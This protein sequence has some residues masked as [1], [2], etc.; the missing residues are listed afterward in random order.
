VKN[1]NSKANY[2]PNQT[3]IRKKKNR[4]PKRTQPGSETTPN[5][6]QTKKRDTNPEVKGILQ[7]REMQDKTRQ[8]KIRRQGY[9]GVKVTLYLPPTKT[10]S[11]S[12]SSLIGEFIV[13]VY[14]S[15]PPYF[16]WSPLVYCLV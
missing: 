1:K 14:H 11:T 6:Q 4:G 9:S 13:A 10:P 2:E 8:E 15:F 12:P 5:P 7:D 3:Q 16:H